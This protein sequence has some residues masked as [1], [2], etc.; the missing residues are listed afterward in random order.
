MSEFVS[1]YLVAKKIFFIRGQKVMLSTD[2]AKLYGAEPKA[3]IQA[4]K[5]NPERFP[6]DF[7]FSLNAGEFANLKSQIV[8]SSWGGSRRALPYA[9]TEYGVAML[10][11]VLRSKRAIQVNIE[12][13]RAF[14]RLREVL[15]SHRA[16]ARRLD[17]LEAKVGAQ[18][19]KIQAVFNAIRELMKEPEK[20]KRKIGFM[21]QEK[22]M[23]YKVW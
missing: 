23:A 22:R 16:L 4:V 20:P 14:S 2:L 19:E 10:S 18:D 17:A 9:F 8:T 12:I 1:E 3:L 21:A 6:P 11:S 15:V 5:R 13:M 7:M